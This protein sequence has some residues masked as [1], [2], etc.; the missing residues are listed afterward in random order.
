MTVLM[1]RGDADILRAAHDLLIPLRAANVY[2]GS[3]R[4]DAGTRQAVQL[5]FSLAQRTV[6][7]LDAQDRRA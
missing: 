3:V 4:A 7:G 1:D 2:V 6:A 5:G